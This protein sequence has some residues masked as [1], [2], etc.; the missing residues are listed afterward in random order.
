VGLASGF[1]QSQHKK[2]SNVLS[3]RYGNVAAPP[4]IRALDDRVFFA[5]LPR[6][7]ARLGEL[8]AAPAT[9]K[10]LQKINC[11]GQTPRRAH[12]LAVSAPRRARRIFRQTAETNR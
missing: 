9:L 1:T 8:R 6:V 3:I 4:P 12:G 2:F 7:R 10:Q 5:A 11:A